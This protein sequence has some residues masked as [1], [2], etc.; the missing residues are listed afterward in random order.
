MNDE[1]SPG[2]VEPPLAGDELTTLTAFLDYQRAVIAR[3][4]HCL[5]HEQLNRTLPPSTLT[6]AKLLR[7]ATLVEATWFRERFLGSDL[8]EPRAS[9]PWDDD[10]DWE[11]T[12][13]VDVAPGQ[14]LAD[15]HAACE[16]S[17]RITAD[18]A[19]LDQLSDLPDR[20]GDHYNLRWI[21]VHM[22][23]EHARHAGHA[24]FLRESI[25][26]VVGD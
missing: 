1:L 9:A 22:I 11:M 24:D 26:G 4:A 17:R 23:E 13:A 21:L 25:D 2:L 8:D 10:V 5:T 7:H 12:T 15:F 16:E 20:T 19:S 3:K 18:A 6:L 14:L